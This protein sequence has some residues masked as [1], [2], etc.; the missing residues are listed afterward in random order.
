MNSQPSFQKTCL[1]VLLLAGCCSA[2]AQP[3]TGT[4]VAQEPVQSQAN[5]P[6]MPADQPVAATGQSDQ[7]PVV[8]VAP[9][10]AGSLV[11]SSDNPAAPD[12]LDEQLPAGELGF[13]ADGDPESADFQEIPSSPAVAIAPESLHGQ[14]TVKE[15]H[16]DAGEVI[17]LFSINPDSSFAGTMTVAGNV[18][19][20][21]SGNW[22]LDGNLITW[23]YTESTPPLMLVDETE[24][25]EIIAVD[26]EKLVYR[27]GKRDVVE[28][29]YRE[30]Y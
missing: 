9:M 29:L 4:P 8:P 16:P 2:S 13:E 12:T 25:D 24:V 28:T 26:S 15:Q 14:W 11:E 17:T 22:Y 27:S 5:L 21:Y 10:P 30:N 6:V 19:W 18:V 23:F 1:A 7:D 20:S 3:V